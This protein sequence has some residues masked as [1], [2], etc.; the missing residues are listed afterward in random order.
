M[1]TSATAL[2]LAALSTS[3]T[4]VQ[5][6]P[7]LRGPTQNGVAPAATVFSKPFDLRVAWRRDLGAGYSAVVVADD[8]VVGTFSDGTDDRIVALDVRS[9]DVLWSVPF[10]PT[11]RGKQGAEDGPSSTPCIAGGRVFAAGPRGR[12]MAIDLVEGRELWS[13]DLVERFNANI[14]VYGFGASPVPVG[15]VV[16]LPMGSLSGTT[17]VAF[18]PATGEVLWEHRAGPADYQ[19]AVRFQEEFEQGLLLAPDSTDVTLIDSASGEA[20]LRLPHVL[21]RPD[22]VYP[23]IVPVDEDRMLFTYDTEIALRRLDPVD[24]ELSLVWRSRELKQCYSPPVAF[25]DAIYG[26]SGTFLVCLDAATGKRQW[27]SREPGARGLILVDGHLVLLTADGDVVVAEATRNGYSEIAR[28]AATQRGGYTA[29]SFADGRIFV[30]NTAGLACVEVVPASNTLAASAG[31]PSEVEWPD[32]VRELVAQMKTAADPEAALD[33][34]WAEHDVP[35]VEG[36]RV[37]FFYRGEAQDVA[38]VGDMTRDRNVPHALRRVPGTDVFHRGYDYDATGLWQYFFLVDWERPVLDPRN[39]RTALALSAIHQNPQALGYPVPTT[40]SLLVMPGHRR[41]AF[42][43]GV[44]DGGGRVETMSLTS[45]FLR[46][47]RDVTVYLPAAYDAGAEELPVLYVLGCDNWLTHGELTRALDALMGERCAPAVVVG[48]P[49]HVGSADRMD[50]DDYA[51]AILQ[52]LAPLVRTRYRVGST[53]VALGASDDANGALALA[54]LAPDR[55]R[56]IA[57]QSPAA[58]VEDFEV[59]ARAEG[60]PSAVYVDWSEY[61]LQLRD[62]NLD[63]RTAA[64]R[65]AEHFRSLGCEVVAEE[66]AAGPGFASWSSRLDRVLAFLLPRYP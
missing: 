57:V 38:L 47:T 55:F 43:D 37:H 42:L 36:E 64:R 5:D 2:T 48:L 52:E 29:P 53:E 60:A 59:L 46:A 44:V 28:L 9:G 3:A 15:E 56:R 39:P 62:E 65:V 20:L 14:S 21:R 33:A 54:A 49:F 13:V 35:L 7:E 66:V 16:Y 22:G 34:W 58:D 63:Y 12:L 26:L 41:A 32:V 30:R 6:W 17:G 19:N 25:G 40:E 61:E 10:G 45:R 31:A 27:K 11:F 23:Q 51:R 1:I 4:V 24:E 8:R 18:D 50:G